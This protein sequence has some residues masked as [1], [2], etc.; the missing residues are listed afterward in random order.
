MK[1]NETKDNLMFAPRCCLPQ[2]FPI[3]SKVLQNCRMGTTGI[4]VSVRRLPFEIQG[5]TSDFVLPSLKVSTDA[6]Q[7]KDPARFQCPRANAYFRHCTMRQLFPSPVFLCLLITE[8]MFNI[9]GHFTA[10]PNL[11]D[12]VPICSCG[13]QCP[14]AS[15]G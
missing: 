8:L 7:T 12:E 4:S 1:N 11:Q 10:R 15:L 9:Y 6:L 13:T 3:S 2:P 5:S 14:V